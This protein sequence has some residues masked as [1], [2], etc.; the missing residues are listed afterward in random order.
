MSDAKEAGRPKLTDEDLELAEL[1]SIIDLFKG[2]GEAMGDAMGKVLDKALDGM[3]SHM[4]D[5]RDGLEAG[6]LNIEAAVFRIDSA[7]DAIGE[8]WTSIP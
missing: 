5:I 4:K 3:E 8:F 1:A 7:R 2:T 6:T